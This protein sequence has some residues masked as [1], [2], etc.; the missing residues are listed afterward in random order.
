MKI[1]FKDYKVQNQF[2]Y[3]PTFHGARQVQATEPLTD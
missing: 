1:I 2:E 3:K